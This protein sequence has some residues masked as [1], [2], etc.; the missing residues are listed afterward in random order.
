M[1]RFPV[2]AIVALVSVIYFLT[3]LYELLKAHF[4]VVELPTIWYRFT[5]VLYFPF[6]PYHN[7]VRDTFLD[8]PISYEQFTYIMWGPLVA[9]FLVVFIG[10]LLIRPAS[11]RKP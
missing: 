9:L 10:A 7:F 2:R 8:S 11:R 6:S 4:W 1:R 5:R 3:S